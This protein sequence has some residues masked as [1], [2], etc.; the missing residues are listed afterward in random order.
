M[1][2]TYNWNSFTLLLTDL[3]HSKRHRNLFEFSV[4]SGRFQNPIP[5]PVPTICQSILGPGYSVLGIDNW[6][7]VSVSGTGSLKCQISGYQIRFGSGCL[8]NRAR[9]SPILKTYAPL[10]MLQ[11]FTKYLFYYSYD[12][13]TSLVKL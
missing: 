5:E 6:F 9:F 4:H 8:K 2:S 11:Y 3:L 13:N 12:N 10:R 1:R 7:L